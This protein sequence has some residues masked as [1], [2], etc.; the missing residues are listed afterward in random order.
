MLH[1][2]SCKMFYIAISW[3]GNRQDAW[4]WELRRKWKP[5]GVKLRESGFR[6]RSAAEVAGKQALDDFI[7]A[8]PREPRSQASE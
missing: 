3:S 4:C 2:T 8:L 5:M 7:A 1:P 6:S